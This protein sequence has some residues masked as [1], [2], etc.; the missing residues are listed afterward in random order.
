MTID[1]LQQGWISKQLFCVKEARQRKEYILLNS[2][3]IKLWKQ[4]N[5]LQLQEVYEWFLGWGLTGV[6]VKL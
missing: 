6:K 2:I 1:A 4:Q 5:N 3:Y